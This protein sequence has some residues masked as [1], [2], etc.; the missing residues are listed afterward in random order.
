MFLKRILLTTSLHVG[1]CSVKILF[2]EMI[3]QLIQKVNTLLAHVILSL[4]CKVECRPRV[5]H[6]ERT[7]TKAITI[8]FCTDM[9]SSCL[10]YYVNNWNKNSQFYARVDNTIKHISHCKHNSY[11]TPIQL[12]NISWLSWMPQQEITTEQNNTQNV[13]R[14]LQN[15]YWEQQES[16]KVPTMSKAHHFQKHD[17]WSKAQN[18]NTI[19]GWNRHY[20]IH[21]S[22]M[23]MSMC[24]MEKGDN[25]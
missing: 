8:S 2:N 23:N 10:F 9:L 6:L 13:N 25:V 5:M 21:N 7:E 4:W 17:V 24:K 18:S 12:T 20:C 15:W 3:T 22:M 11:I 19:Q 16:M 14:H 1:S